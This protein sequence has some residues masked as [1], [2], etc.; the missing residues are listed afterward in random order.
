MVL[1]DATRLVA[2]AILGELHCNNREIL[3]L[4][5]CG[6][7]PFAACRQDLKNLA[8]WVARDPM[9]NQI[10]AFYA[11][12]ILAKAANRLGFTIQPKPA[13]LRLRLQRFFFKGLLLLY[14]QEGLRRIQYG[15]TAN[16]YPADAWLS[17]RELLR[18]YHGSC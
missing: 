16:T 9:A 12:T 18:R 13:T 6:R 17:Q 3:E 2:G 10:E 1:P 7:N 5:R 15:S 8:N 14:S 4:V 11:C